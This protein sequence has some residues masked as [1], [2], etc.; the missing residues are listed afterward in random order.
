MNVARSFAARAES[1]GLGIGME[2]HLSNVF[3]DLAD[4]LG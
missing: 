2:Q 3:L 1:E 4:V